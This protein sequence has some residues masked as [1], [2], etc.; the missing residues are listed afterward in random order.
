MVLLAD[1]T[2]I[3]IQGITDEA[4]AKTA[5][6][7]L[8]A[9]DF[10]DSALTVYVESLLEAKRDG[11]LSTDHLLVA[12][13]Q[14][15]ILGTIWACEHAGRAASL[16]YPKTNL[17]DSEQGIELSHMLMKSLKKR[18]LKRQIRFGQLSFTE[19]TTAEETFLAD[20]GFC[21]KTI[22]QYLVASTTARPQF[23]QSRLQFEPFTPSQTERLKETLEKTYLGSLDCPEATQLRPLDEVVAGYQEIGDYHPG[24]WFFL[25]QNGET[26]GCLLLNDHPS[27]QQWELV[28]FGLIPSARGKSLGQEV[29][30]FAKWQGKRGGRDRIVLA[31]DE[32]N[33]PALDIYRRLGFLQWERKVIYLGLLKPSD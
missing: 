3:K 15:K 11:N 30:D 33:Q 27:D 26:V 21:K 23:P 32:R 25:R 16:F 19:P 20:Y 31:V 5:W 24:R 13:Y 29:V 8:F 10:S 1:L 18:L 22:L 12:T 2:T 14:G 9:D 6:Q 7:L 28:Y 4:Q 17:D